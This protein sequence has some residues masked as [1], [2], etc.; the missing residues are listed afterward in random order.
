VFSTL[1]VN[2]TIGTDA[3]PERSSLHLAVYLTQRR[4]QLANYQKKRPAVRGD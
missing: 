2:P 1:T 4:Q 3:R